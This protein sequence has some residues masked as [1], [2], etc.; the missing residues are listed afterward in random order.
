[1]RSYKQSSVVPCWADLLRRAV[2]E[3]GIVS[4]A[5]SRFHAYS[6]RNQLL[7]LF[8]CRERGIEPGP[9]A[10]YPR[11]KEL[12]RYVRKGEKAITLCQPVR[13]K[14]T[15]PA[16][17]ENPDSPEQQEQEFTYTCFVYIP[18]W[19]VV[20]QTEGQEYMPEPLPGWNTDTALSALNIERALFT[21]LDGNVQGYAK[22]RTVAINPVAEQPEST[23]FHEV[24]HIVLGHTSEGSVN[25]DST[26][27][28]PR[29]IRELEAECVA[30][31]CC[32]SLGL[33]GAA[34]SRGY[35]QSW[36]HGQEVPERSAQRIFHAADQ[37][38][39]AGQKG[40]NAEVQA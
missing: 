37:I 28:T 39:K 5:Y 13:R 12:G 36:F 23:L 17:D 1:M 4:K 10:T 7:A 22:H 20:S 30:L 27:R 11:W 15:K 32:E 40:R 16:S 25:S 21:M 8:Q 9:I 31:L 29:D 14:G 6:V 18:H 33:P 34:E 24:A 3:P 35:I 38:L 26:D 2:T 19:F